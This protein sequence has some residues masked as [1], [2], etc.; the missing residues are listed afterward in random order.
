MQERE[1][2]VTFDEQIVFNQLDKSKNAIWSLLLAGGYLKAEEVEYRGMLLEPWYHLR[3]TN[4]ETYSMFS[5]MFKDGLM[6]P[7]RT[8]MSS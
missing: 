5:N 6:I 4:L 1:I 2:V 8:I 7:C 3:I